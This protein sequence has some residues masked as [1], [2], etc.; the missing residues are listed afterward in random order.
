MVN[1]SLSIVLIL[2]FS[3]HAALAELIYQWKENKGQ[4][5]FS[6][7]LST[8]VTGKPAGVRPQSDSLIPHAQLTPTGG[9]ERENKSGAS[10]QQRWLL[11]FP[12]VPPVGTGDSSR[13]SGWT[14][15]QFFDSEQSCNHYK[16]T[17]IVDVLRLSDGLSSINW[18]LLESNCIP[19][20]EFISGKEANV[21]VVTTRFEPVAGG[22]SSHLLYG[23][24]FNRGQAT[25][26]N[27]VMKYQIRDSNGL[28]VMQGDVPIASDIDSL[29]FSEFRTPSFGGRSLHGLSVKA[30]AD[31]QK[32]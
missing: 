1:W 32:K 12:P 20:S 21:I 15:A 8:G 9:D 18:Q 16:A 19:A 4:W 23:K 5:H 31:W 24:V 14:P 22:F 29:N 13:Y 11:I 7:V 6:D 30:D 10:L 3:D 17:L 25:A 2:V 27:V 26:R 28:N